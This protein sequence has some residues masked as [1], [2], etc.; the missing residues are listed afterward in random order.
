MLGSRLVFLVDVES[1]LGS[2]SMGFRNP[3]VLGLGYTFIPKPILH[4]LAIS[5]ACGGP[6]LIYTIE[7][8]FP[9][10]LS[11]NLPQ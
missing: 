1:P 6:T 2:L 9:I 5:I 3:V 4:K 8:S 11:L 10:F 7:W